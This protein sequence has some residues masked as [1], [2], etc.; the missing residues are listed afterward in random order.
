MPVP[1]HDVILWQHDVRECPGH[2]SE[3][4]EQDLGILLRQ[5]SLTNDVPMLSGGDECMC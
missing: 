1:R 4:I 3:L 2:R 5:Q